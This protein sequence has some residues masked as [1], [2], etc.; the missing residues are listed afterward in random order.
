MGKR[1]AVVENVVV[2]CHRCI[3]IEILFGGLLSFSIVNFEKVRFYLKFPLGNHRHTVEVTEHFKKI[4]W[5][6]QKI[7]ANTIFRVIEE[8]IVQD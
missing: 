8:V 4:E 5:C 2:H 7:L 3:S 1:L 6:C